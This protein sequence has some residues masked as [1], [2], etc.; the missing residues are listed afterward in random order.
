MILASIYLQN[1]RS[2]KERRFD[3]STKTTV[4][5]GPNT[6]GKTNLSEAI[7]MLSLGKS[8]RTSSEADCVS[9]GQS[10]GR[11]G[12]MV[13]DGEANIKQE[14]VLATGATPTGRLGKK[15]LINGVS[16]ARSSF[17]GFLPTVLFRPEELDIVIDGPSVRRDFLDTL[18]EQVDRN[19]Y[20]ATNNYQRALRQRNALLDTAKEIHSTRSARSG[21]LAEQFAYWDDLLI[22]NGQLITQ[23]REEFVEYCNKSEKDIFDFSTHYD[24]STISKERLL[25]YKEAEMGAGNTLVGP[26]RDDLQFFMKDKVGVEREVKAFGSRGQE[27]L[28]VLQLKILQINYM[29]EKL[30]QRPLLVLDDIF[31]ELDSGHIELVLDMVTSNQTIIT[32]THKEFIPIKKLKEYS[33]IE[34]NKNF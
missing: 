28:V 30:G 22:T 27:R 6:A 11:V 19:Y 32:T 8:F 18:L 31:S 33:I 24:K 3:F 7:I 9:F 10:V 29:T 16:K 34:L 26:H 21:Q 25:Q 20:H 4:I 2:Y 17:V 13:Q 15:Y 23:K 5:V 12:G 1:F 14:V